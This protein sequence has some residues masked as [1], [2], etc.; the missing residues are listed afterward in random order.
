MAVVSTQFAGRV[1]L[2]R[3]KG[4]SF[5]REALSRLHELV[6]KNSQFVIATTR[7]SSWPIRTRR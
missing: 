5:D 3:D 6:Q 4:E 7:R 1:T 2:L